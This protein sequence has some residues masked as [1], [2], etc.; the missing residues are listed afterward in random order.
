MHLIQLLDQQLLKISRMAAGRSMDIFLKDRQY[1][2]E[3]QKSVAC[4]FILFPFSSTALA[5]LNLEFFHLRF[6]L[7][8][9]FS[10]ASQRFFT[11]V[12]RG[13]KSGMM[14]LKGKNACSTPGSRSIMWPRST[15]F[16]W[17]NR[18]LII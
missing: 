8:L 9:F 5:Q 1:S 16:P 15:D 10:G 3:M 18:P 6:V 13:K 14:Y 12:N 17:I 2:V 4:H 7:N 11:A